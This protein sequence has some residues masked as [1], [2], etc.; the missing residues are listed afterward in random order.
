M[1]WTC[2]CSFSFMADVALELLKTGKS[3]SEQIGT[4][5]FTALSLAYRY[6]YGLY[7]IRIT[8]TRLLRIK[9]VIFVRLNFIFIYYNY[10]K[11]V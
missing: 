3:I 6:G 1:I 4:C 8:K 2:R 9:I 5:C 11:I 7:H 10:M